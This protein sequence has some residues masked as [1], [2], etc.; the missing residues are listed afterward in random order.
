MRTLDVYHQTPFL[1]KLLDYKRAAYYEH[2]DSSPAF[3][4]NT[5]PV[6]CDEGRW[7]VG[8]YPI[9]GYL[10]R[11]VLFPAF[12]PHDPGAYAKAAMVF[13]LFLKTT[14]N[15]VD[16]LAVIQHN[17]FVLGREPCVI[18][19]ILADTDYPHPQWIEYQHRVA[20][21]STAEAA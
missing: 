21:F 15:P 10:D 3:P 7:I 18:D 16:W 2:G 5:D 19:L 8:V 12:F 17:P 14:P 13:D 6:I 1:K 4:T 9:M 11:R 20:A